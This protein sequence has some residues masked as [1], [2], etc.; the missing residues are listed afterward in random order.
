[1]IDRHIYA[2]TRKLPEK[3]REEIANEIREL[4]LDMIEDI[5]DTVSEEEKIEKVLKILGDPEKLASQYRGKERYLI[6][7][8]YIDKYIFVMKIVSLSIFIGI[9][10]ALGIGGV[11][12]AGGIIDFIG[13]Y[14][15]ALI[16]S[17]LQ[18]AAWVTV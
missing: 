1:M 18:G 11:F 13:S 3:S 16:S 8:N 15:D 6:G 12:S 4:I 10:I 17:L 2:V 7:P 14:I 5:E 9:S